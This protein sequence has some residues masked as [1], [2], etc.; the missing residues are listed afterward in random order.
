M[1][2]KRMPA[3]R[4][5]HGFTLVEMVVVMLIIGVIAGI[6]VPSLIGYVNKARRRTDAV[7]GKRIGD[8]IMTI[9]YVDDSV[10]EGYGGKMETANQ[11]FHRYNTTDGYRR[12]IWTETGQETC[13]FTIVAKRNGA[14]AKYAGDGHIAYSWEGNN[15]IEA[16]TKALNKLEE[17][18]NGSGKDN[19]FAIPIQCRS[20]DGNALNRWFIVL[21]TDHKS[22]S[23][24][25]N[26]EFEIWIGNDSN[27]PSSG[28][29][30]SHALN[31]IY[32]VYPN[33]SVEY[34]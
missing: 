3:S 18:P 8:D 4:K 31:P 9:L 32:R 27:I 28:T 30:A 10:Y 16:F 20:T 2:S 25:N 14:P 26:Y 17:V 34:K 24:V 23:D 13:D 7:N 21:R 5:V 12:I 19:T 29:N 22:K 15:Q 1:K 11:S 33:P 6:L